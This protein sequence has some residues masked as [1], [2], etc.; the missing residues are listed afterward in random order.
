VRKTKNKILNDPIYGFITIPSKFIYKIIEH[1]YFQRLRRI[2]QLGLSCLVYPG[3]NH[4]RFHHA[5][6]A[7]HLMQ[8]AINVLKNKNIKITNEEEEGL[9]IAILLHDIG[10]GPFSHALE[11][12]L[13]RSISHEKISLIF[14]E[15]LNK[16]FKGKLKTAIDI[17]KN[18]YKKK[19]LHQLIS[20]QIDVDRLDYLNRDSFY[21][22]VAEG[23]VNSKRIIDM[24]NVYN[25]ELVIEKKGLYSIEKFLLARKLMYLQVYTHKT[26]LS[27]EYTLMNILKRAKEVFKQTNDLFY[28]NSIKPFLNNKVNLCEV[29]KRKGNLNLFAQIDDYDVLTCIKEWTNSKDYILSSLCQKIVK[30]EL[31]KIH[32]IDNKNTDVEKKY[33]TKSKFK[34][35]KKNLK[36]FIFKIQTKNKIYDTKNNP[37][38][39]MDQKGTNIFLSNI[40]K[41]LHFNKHQNTIIKNFICFPKGYKI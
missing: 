39:I 5:I 22:G 11:N 34:I 3:A 33:L 21:S 12:S 41:D 24:Y 38:K 40:E 30:R 27:A 35:S 2:S 15:E 29:N 7:M 23:I 28:T 10:H 14:M 19:F 4:T 13:M 26:V 25:Q 1:P 18:N 16:E 17:F 9:L 31:L 32:E 8:Q 37:I 20:S 6:G 36:Y